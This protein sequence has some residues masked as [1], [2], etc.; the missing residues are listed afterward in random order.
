MILVIHGLAHAL[1]K[2]RV[3]LIPRMLYGVNRILFGLVLPP[4]V[5]IGGGTV[6]G[7]QGLGVVIHARAVVGRNVSIGT[8]VTIGGRSGIFEVP[9][10]GDGVEIGSGAKILGPVTIGEN[11][12]I[13][14]NAVVLIDVPENATAVGIP[15]RVVC[16]T[17]KAPGHG[18]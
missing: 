1:H 8:G 5:Q 6:L 13:G 3:P 7:Y 17:P 4:S 18:G 11:A 14:A 12:K 16:R 10:I 15:A 9:R 2:K